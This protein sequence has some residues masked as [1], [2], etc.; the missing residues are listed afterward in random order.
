MEKPHVAALRRAISIAGSQSA[1]ADG[2]SRYLKRPTLGQQTISKWLKDE[3]LL[4]AIYWPA[5]EHV[6]DN[7]VTRAHLRPDVFRSGKAA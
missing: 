4:D 3:T 1:L 6:T 5:F 7:G 2:L